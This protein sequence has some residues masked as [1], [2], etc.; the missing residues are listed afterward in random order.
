M[1]GKICTKNG[2]LYVKSYYANKYVVKIT[3]TDIEDDQMYFSGG[4]SSGNP[5]SD[6]DVYSTPPNFKPLMSVR[7][8]LK[9]PEMSYLKYKRT[10]YCNYG[11]EY[12]RIPS[13]HYT[14]NGIAGKKAVVV[15]LANN[16]ETTL[17]V[18]K[19]KK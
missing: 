8:V 10:E 1:V 11:D 19:N 7:D 16:K 2:D 14:Y 18:S 6:N 4:H 15:D 17:I 3:L 12:K 5:D 13:Y 9:Q